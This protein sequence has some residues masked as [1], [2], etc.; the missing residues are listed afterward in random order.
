[1]FEEHDDVCTLNTSFVELQ[2]L[3]RLKFSHYSI[4]FQLQLKTLSRFPYSSFVTVKFFDIVE[5]AL[6]LNLHEIFYD[7][8]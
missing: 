4:P 3:K 2:F 6:I 1:V 7:G 5:L 8:H